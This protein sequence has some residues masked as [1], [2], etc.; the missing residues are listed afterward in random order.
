MDLARL[1][2]VHVDCKLCWM[3]WQGGTQPKWIYCGVPPDGPCLV[4]FGPPWCCALLSGK[5]KVR[6]RSRNSLTA[7]FVFLIC[8]PLQYKLVHRFLLGALGK[9]RH[10]SS[11][12]MCVPARRCETEAFGWFARISI[13]DNYG[14]WCWESRRVRRV[15]VIP[16]HSL[17]MQRSQRDVRGFRIETR[18]GGAQKANGARILTPQNHRIV[19]MKFEHRPC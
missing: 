17:E 8:P 7:R 9:R 15:A 4:A 10:F 6:I 1:I 19:Y 3:P 12:W 2:H 11:G 18:C 16:A 5:S 14:Q 13:D